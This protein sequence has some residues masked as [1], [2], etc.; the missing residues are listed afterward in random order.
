MSKRVL[1]AKKNVTCKG[2]EAVLYR[3]VKEGVT[4]VHVKECYMSRSSVTCRKVSFICKEMF[5]VTSFNVEMDNGCKLVIN[6]DRS[7]YVN[8]KELCYM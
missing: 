8:V 6:M 4:F 7:K 5:Y 3:R 1:L 2:V